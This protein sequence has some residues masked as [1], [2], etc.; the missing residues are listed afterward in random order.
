MRQMIKSATAVLH[1]VREQVFFLSFSLHRG[2]FLAA[3]PHTSHFPRAV[4]PPRSPVSSSKSPIFLLTSPPFL[5]TSPC[6]LSTSTTFEKKQWTFFKKQGRISEKQW[7]FSTEVHKEE[8]TVGKYNKRPDNL[9]FHSTSPRPFL[10]LLSQIILTILL[11][12]N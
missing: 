6:L 9:L 11:N 1:F 12:P 2:P 5:P 7:T 8:I 10:L 3:C 4:S